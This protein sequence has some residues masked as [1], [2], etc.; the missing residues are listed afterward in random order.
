M[1]EKIFWGCI[2]GVTIYM[3]IPFVITRIIRFG[4]FSEARTP[5]ALALTFDDGP[6][7]KYTPQLL[8]LLKKHDAKA[9]FFV[10]GSMAE[11]YPDLI[12][13]MHEEGHQ[14]GIHNYTHKTNWLLFPWSVR[15]DHLY[16]TADIVEKIIGVRPDYYR[17]PWGIINFFDFGLRKKFHII[18]WSV[19]VSDWRSKDMRD[20]RRM[21]DLLLKKCKGGSVVLLHDS[22]ETLGAVPEAPKYMLIALDDVLAKLKSQGMKFVRVDE[23]MEMDRQERA[24]KESL[25]KRIM[26]KTFLW[27]DNL[28]HKIIGTKYIDPADPFLKFRVRRYQ[29]KHPI[30][31]DDG[32]T[33]KRGDPIIE[34]HLNNE[35]L[36]RLGVSARSTTQ[37]SVQLI[38]SMQGLMPKLKEMLEKDPDLQRIKGLYGISI[39]HRGAKR[40]GY[41]VID[42]PSGLFTAL[43][44]I[45]LKFLLF[46]VHPQ[47]RERLTTKS[48]LLEPK[49]I[50]I[51]RAEVLRRY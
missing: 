12:Q 14:V 17:P 36:H 16:R 22:G 39:I 29:G 3:L 9:T 51:S 47:G 24:A 20:A 44:R 15:T 30:H 23:L 35:E 33:I 13:R 46:V 25:G 8:D 48:E 5:D 49:I 26:V 38:R 1:E 50:A 10:L 42:L 11:R 43:T 18:L 34:L 28:V 7:P 4:V 21:R 31:L 6:H 19:M 37:L 32:E 27:Y 2:L 45:Y 40:F 41:S